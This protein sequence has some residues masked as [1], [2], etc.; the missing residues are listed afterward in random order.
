MNDAMTPK[1]ATTH[2]ARLNE[3]AAAMV[4]FDDPAD[5][6]RASRGLI[7]THDT[8]RIERDGQMVWDTARHDFLRTDDPPPD[9][10]HPGLWR[11]G[12]GAGL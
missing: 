12:A 7:A 2:T 3:A 5:F 1:P 9:S 8:G 10:V 6:E 11:Q 4:N